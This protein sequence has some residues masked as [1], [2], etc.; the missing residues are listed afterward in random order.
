MDK[1][2]DI[3]K[4]RSSIAEIGVGIFS[5]YGNAQILYVKR[6]YVPDGMVIVILD[7]VKP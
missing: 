7:M 5:D 4:G 2:E 1:A 6:G 3:I